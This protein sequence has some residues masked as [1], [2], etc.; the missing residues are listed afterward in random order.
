MYL[1]ENQIVGPLFSCIKTEFYRV[2][3]MTRS[4]IEMLVTSAVEFPRQTYTSRVTRRSK[5]RD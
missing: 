1:S 4:M 3:H 2:V 5:P